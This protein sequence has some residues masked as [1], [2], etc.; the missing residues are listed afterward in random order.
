MLPWSA[1]LVRGPS[2][3]P[4][5][6]LI[7]QEPELPPSPVSSILQDT[8]ILSWSLFQH[9]TFP[10][11]PIPAWARAGVRTASTPT[12]AIV[13]IREAPSTA[14]PLGQP[15]AEDDAPVP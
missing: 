11:V 13:F 6:V 9:W 1:Q 8:E 3:P 12:T 10:L 2:Q 5:N 15:N 7:R 14:R 4:R